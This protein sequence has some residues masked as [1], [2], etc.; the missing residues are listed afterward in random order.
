MTF[1]TLMR[2]ANGSAIVRKTYAENGSSLRVFARDAVARHFVVGKAVFGFVRR[3]IRREFD[4][5]I[6]QDRQPDE[7]DRRNGVN[8]AKLAVGDRFGE[9]RID[10]FFGQRAVLEIFFHQR[11][12]RFGD[13]LDQALAGRSKTSLPSS[14]IGISFALPSSSN[15]YAF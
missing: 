10:V 8:R 2:P 1:I 12:V 5:V 6:E 14:G 4:D 7:V 9:V 13:E 11:V 3:R 15:S